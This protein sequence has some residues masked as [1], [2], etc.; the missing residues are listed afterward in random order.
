M[1]RLTKQEL[2]KFVKANEFERQIDEVKASDLSHQGSY[3]QRVKQMKPRKEDEDLDVFNLSLTP[4][5][6][7]MNTD[8]RTMRSEKMVSSVPSTDLYIN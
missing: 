5:K 8:A 7:V 1:A 2:S 4:G 6:F 3:D